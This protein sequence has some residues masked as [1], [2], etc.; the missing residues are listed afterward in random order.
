ML[1]EKMAEVAPETYQFL[2]DIAPAIQTSPFHD[3]IVGEMDGII[4]RA[5][6]MGGLGK[7]LG[8]NVAGGVAMALAGDLYEAAKR[9]L[10]KSRNYR[11]MLDENPDLKKMPA[12]KVQESFNVLHQFNPEFASNPTVAGAFVR[13]NSQFPEF[14]VK[15]LGELVGSR[16]SI[17]DTRKLPNANLDLKGATP[18]D[19]MEQEKSHLQ[20]RKMQRE[21][22]Q[23]VARGMADQA[24]LSMR[25]KQILR[26]IAEDRGSA[27]Q[28]RRGISNR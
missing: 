28:G 5:S 24:G 26:Q 25:Q 23:G 12:R 10:T 18:P 7:Q 2:V 20:L 3:E 15:Q 21:D 11:S 4:K 1:M 16:K 17:A 9:G 14:D 13:K 22:T 8:V 6:V 27:P 19:S